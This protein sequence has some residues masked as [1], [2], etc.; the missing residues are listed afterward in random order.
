MP[1]MPTSPLQL[2]PDLSCDTAVILGQ[3]NV[4]LDVARILLTPPEHLEVSGQVRGWRSAGEVTRRRGRPHCRGQAS[5]LQAEPEPRARLPWPQAERG[6][7]KAVPELRPVP[8]PFALSTPAPRAFQQ[9]TPFGV[10]QFSAQLSLPQ[11]ALYLPLIDL[12]AVSMHVV[13]TVILH[14][15]TSI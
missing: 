4:A 8:V 7:C 15:L 6:R 5:S 14:L 11:E 1:M 2:A 10:S 3:G 9:K 12:S 13:T